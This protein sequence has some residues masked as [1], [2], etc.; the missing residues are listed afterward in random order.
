MRVICAYRLTRR[1]RR[2]SDRSGRGIDARPPWARAI[3]PGRARSSSH[4]VADIVKTI[5][6]TQTLRPNP[7][8]RCTWFCAMASD[9]PTP[10]AQPTTPDSTV[11]PTERRASSR[12]AA[13]NATTR[14]P[15][16]DS[17]I[18]APTSGIRRVGTAR[19]TSG[20]PADAVGAPPY[21][22]R[23]AADAPRRTRR[24]HERVTTDGQ[25]AERRHPD[26]RLDP[27]PDDQRRRR[28]RGAR[29][30]RPRRAPRERRPGPRPRPDRS[31]HA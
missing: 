15:G 14:I 10:A 28:R 16:S 11:T 24:C 4:T 17:A 7:A 6:N 13:R 29:A 27:R 1:P 31:E 30:D 12:R 23:A 8:L 2:C 26:R 22:A 25:E 18:T 19:V 9:S 3:A 21:A 20:R 5:E